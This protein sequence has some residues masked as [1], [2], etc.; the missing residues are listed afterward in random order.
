MT[1]HTHPLFV[2]CCLTSRQFFFFKHAKKRTNILG[3]RNVTWQVRCVNL[4]KR[5]CKVA[6]EKRNDIAPEFCP[7][8]RK[9]H[10]KVVFSG[11]LLLQLLLQK[12][13]NHVCIPVHVFRKRSGTVYS[14]CS[15]TASPRPVHQRLHVPKVRQWPGGTRMSIVPWWLADLLCTHSVPKALETCTIYPPTRVTGQENVT[16]R[17]G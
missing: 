4:R 15:N 14:A 10:W 5:Y 1:A 2:T 7:Y 9:K 11:F 13:R 8:V 6:Y 16:R 3:Q 12:L 17:R